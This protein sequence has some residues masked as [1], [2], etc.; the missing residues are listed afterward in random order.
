MSEEIH[1]MY[2]LSFYEEVVGTLSEL[3]EKEGFL[4]ARIAGLDILFPIEL[5]AKLRPLVGMRLG[6]LHSDIFGK[7]YLFRVLSDP[8]SDSVDSGRFRYQDG[9]QNS[10]GAI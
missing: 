8:N 7:E 9:M 6:I 4:I 10:E 3:R 1:K 2:R 5:E